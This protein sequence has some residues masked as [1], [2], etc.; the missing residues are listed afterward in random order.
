[1]IVWL[2]EKMNAE[3]GNKLLKILEEPPAQTL[4]MLVTEAADAVLPTLDSRTQHFHLPP[5]SE[6]DLA[7]MLRTRYAIQPD[8]ATAIA[9]RSEGSVLRAIENIHLNE[10]NR[11]FFDFFIRMMRLAYA[12]RIKEMKAWSEEVA[13]IGRERQKNFLDY[14]QQMIRENFIFNLRKPAMNYMG[15]EETQF[16]TRFS[17]FV[18]EK[19]V[20][21]ITNELALAGRHIEQNVNAK[22]VFFDLAL[23]MIVLLLRYK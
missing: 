4:F 8:D 20:I 15:R 12:R 19:N 5:L 13:A 9:H 18:S 23:K 14:C 10:E 6:A 3:C 7:D 16:A 11:L 22:F 17:P 1:M 2:P 21:G